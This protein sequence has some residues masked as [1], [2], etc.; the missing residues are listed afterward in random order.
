MKRKEPLTKINLP[1]LKPEE[2]RSYSTKDFDAIGLHVLDYGNH[3]LLRANT[4]EQEQKLWQYLDV[5]SIRTSLEQQA[6][7][8]IRNAHRSNSFTASCYPVGEIEGGQLVVIALR[9][10]IYADGSERKTWRA[11]LATERGLDEIQKSMTEDIEAT[12]QK[13]NDLTN[14]LGGG[15]N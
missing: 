13:W 6:R 1:A 8:V 3:A 4:D 14:E 9:L 15:T 12:A 2:I 10:S 11:F 5:D 7:E